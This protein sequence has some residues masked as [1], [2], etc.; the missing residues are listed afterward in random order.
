M[1]SEAQL[2]EEGFSEEEI[3][4]RLEDRRL[5]AAPPPRWFYKVGRVEEM[6][7]APDGEDEMPF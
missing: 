6:E 7:L 4:R 3:E 2:R 1:I 5:V